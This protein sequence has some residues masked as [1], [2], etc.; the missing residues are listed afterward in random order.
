MVTIKIFLS[1]LFLRGGGL[2]RTVPSTHRNSQAMC[3]IRTAAAGLCHSH[4]IAMSELC[5]QPTPQLM[6]IPDT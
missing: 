2:F 6:A 1:S 3:Q 4:S 5:L